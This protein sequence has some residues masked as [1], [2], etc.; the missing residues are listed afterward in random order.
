[1]PDIKTQRLVSR[2][3][4]NVSA[5]EQA[6]DNLALAKNHLS[7]ASS[8]LGNWLTPGDA[9]SGESFNIWINGSLLTVTVLAGGTKYQIRYREKRRAEGDE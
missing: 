5:V 1:M 8:E 7:K 9:I 3:Q 4:L 6:E 2:W